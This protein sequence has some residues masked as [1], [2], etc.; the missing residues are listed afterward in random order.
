M[1]ISRYV[2]VHGVYDFLGELPVSCLLDSDVTVLHMHQMR[3]IKLHQLQATETQTLCQCVSEHFV[4]GSLVA[5]VT[6][7]RVN[8]SV[9]CPQ[10]RHQIPTALLL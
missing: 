3:A 7:Y 8:T 4:N 9:K 10:A 2:Y 6:K 1:S 5:N